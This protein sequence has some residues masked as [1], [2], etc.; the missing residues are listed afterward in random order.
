MKKINLRGISEIL[1][2]KEMKQVT[3]G[4]PGGSNNGVICSQYSTSC[5]TSKDCASNQMCTSIN[6]NS[7]SPCCW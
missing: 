7:Y 5:R 1:N 2:E 4:S 3:G 6:G